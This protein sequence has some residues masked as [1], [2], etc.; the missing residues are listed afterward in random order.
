MHSIHDHGY[1]TEDF[2][3]R[4]N[5]VVWR[6]KVAESWVYVYLL[7]EFQSRVDPYM[8]LRM[9]VYQ[10]LLY[11]ELI[12]S[13]EVSPG[14]LPPILPIVLYNGSQRWTADTDVYEL[15]ADV[16]GFME[17]F[18]PHARYFL[19]DEQ[20]HTDE[21]LASQRNVVAAIFR[22]EQYPESMSEVLDR[23]HEWLVDQPELQRSI[24]AWIRAALRQRPEMGQ[25]LPEVA[26]LQELKKMMAD[27]WEA[28]IQKRE[29]KVRQE[30]LQ[31]GRQEG[32]Q[33]GLQRGL[34]EGESLALQRLLAK[35]FGEVPVS[36][37]EMIAQASSTQIET[38]LDRVLDADSLEALFRS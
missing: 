14:A 16:P 32:R 1:I 20:T 29:D 7:I 22:L 37:L 31:E 33:E 11:Q 12:R 28:W 3:S 23:L 36:V 18:K 21:E 34:Q 8:A 5:D 10:G 24:A 13:K 6:F 30:S 2:Q 38:W 26:S 17:H 25:E 35:R 15:I 9:M 4:A 27:R 19:I